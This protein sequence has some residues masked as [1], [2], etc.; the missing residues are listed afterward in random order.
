MGKNTIYSEIRVSESRKASELNSLS[1]CFGTMLQRRNC[2]LCRQGP[3][4]NI[5]G[6]ADHTVSVF[7]ILPL[8]RESCHR[9]HVYKGGLTV[10]Q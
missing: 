8:E 3:D 6:F 2:K 7:S 4:S 1:L 10:L 5:S 9:Q